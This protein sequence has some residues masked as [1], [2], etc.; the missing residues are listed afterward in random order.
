MTAEKSSLG[1][2]KPTLVVMSW[3]GGERFARCLAS[4]APAIAHFS[5]I[6][7]SITSDSHSA[8][9]AKAM[10][11]QIDHPSVEVI[12]TGSEL[13]TMQHQAFWVDYLNKSGMRPNEWIYWLAYDDEVR[14]TGIEALVDD[15]GNWPLE[16]GTAY[17]GPWAMRHESAEEIWRGDPGASLESWTSFPTEGPT[18]ASVT[19]W[20]RGQ[21]RQPTYMQMSGSVCQFASFLELRDGKPR[22]TGPMRIEMATAATRVNHTI[23]EF[24]SPVSIIYGRS[25]SDRASYGKVARKEDIHLM[26]WLLRYARSE[27]GAVPDVVGILTD[28]ATARISRK[29][30]PAEE[31]RVRGMVSP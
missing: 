28:A 10:A 3:R 25:N 26:R 15:Q 29:P 30:Q 11:F 18:V 16:Q 24:P 1:A 17:F 6:V 27:V 8:D 31:W 4:I 12:C 21:L 13:P 5:R 22:K 2:N 19:N 7:L 14:L 20:I 23:R 9:M